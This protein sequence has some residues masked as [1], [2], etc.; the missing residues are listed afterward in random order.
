[1]RALVTYLTGLI[2]ISSPWFSSA[3]PKELSERETAFQENFYAVKIRGNRIWIVGYYGTI[4]HSKDRGATWEIQ[5][6]GTR[7]ALY[8]A[9]FV[10]DEKGWIS[11]SYGTILRTQDGG[12]SWVRQTSSTDEHLFGLD[13]VSERKGWA[14]GSRGTLLYTNDGGLSWHNRSIEE[15]V[16][17]NSVSFI[18]PEL[19]WAVGEFG[20]IYHTKDSGKSW[21]KQKSPVEV[22]PAS[23]ESRNLF[24]LLFPDSKMGWALGLDGVILKTQ[25]GERWK[26]THR[27][28]ATPKYVTDH[29]LFAVAHFDGRL[30]AVGERGT[31]IVSQM[32]KDDWQKAET[33]WPPLSFNGIEFGP[34]GLGLIVGNRG[35]ISRTED[36]GKQW[37]RIRIVP[38]GAGRGI[39]RVQ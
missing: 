4:L 38:Q 8:R 39:S 15:D 25:N 26:I 13:F 31:V 12:M 23:G 14:S 16:I 3:S 21:I 24:G 6:S 20:V 29:H 11:G 34:D 33:K 2:L 1:M 17:L 22:S 36:G 9:A 10:S 19:G 30:W 37:N 5:L 35:F 18:S 27:N 28:G 7:K 32:G